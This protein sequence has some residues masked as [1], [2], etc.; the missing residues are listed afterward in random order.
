MTVRGGSWNARD[1][2]K[3]RIRACRWRF[4]PSTYQVRADDTREQAALRMASDCIGGSVPEFLLWCAR[5]V[6]Q[7]HKRLKGV[8]AHLRKL[9]REER[10]RKREEAKREAA[11][12]KTAEEL[13]DA[14]RK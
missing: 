13:W 9:D 10:A 1:R 8:R 3:D 6:L 7:H 2:L 14:A 4:D 5:Y 12:R 11:Q